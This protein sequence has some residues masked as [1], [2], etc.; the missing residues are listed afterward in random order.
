MTP[1]VAT[2]KGDPLERAQTLTQEDDTHQNAQQG[3][4]KVSQAGF[5]DEIGIDRPDVNQPIDPDQ[6]S[7]GQIY[8]EDTR[9][10]GCLPESLE[11][12]GGEDEAEQHE[13]GPGDTVADHLHG[14]HLVEP[15][16]VDREKPP[17]NICP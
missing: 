12:P 5:D 3:I 7:G 6:D 1:T 9:L 2:V 13:I 14:T 8:T 15:F 11:L 10:E 17:Q 4:N 16:P